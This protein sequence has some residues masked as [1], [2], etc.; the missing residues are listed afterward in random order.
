MTHS[1][2]V[3]TGGKG[4]RKCR[5]V[6]KSYKGGKERGGTWWKKNTLETIRIDFAEEGEYAYF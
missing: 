4:R 2:S 3:N 1:K 6:S 5:N